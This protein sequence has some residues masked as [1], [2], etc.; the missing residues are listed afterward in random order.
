MSSSN[1]VVVSALDIPN[2]GG[3]RA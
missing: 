1:V 2:S 3:R